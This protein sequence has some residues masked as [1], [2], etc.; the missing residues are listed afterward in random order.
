MLTILNSA[1]KSY[2][3]AVCV[4]DEI[5]NSAHKAVKDLMVF[6]VGSQYLNISAGIFYV[7]M[8]DDKAAADWV[9]VGGTGNALA[10]SCAAL[11]APTAAKWGADAVLT[12]LKEANVK[13]PVPTTW[14]KV[15]IVQ[16]NDALAKAFPDGIEGE[17]EGNVRDVTYNYANVSGDVSDSKLSYDILALADHNVSIVATFYNNTTEV[18]V[19]KFAININA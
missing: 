5:F 8:D 10:V 12:G 7:R 18:G 4:G 19:Q 3:H 2:K 11:S 6:P 9:A 14:T 1:D 13:I 17:I 15:R 16:V